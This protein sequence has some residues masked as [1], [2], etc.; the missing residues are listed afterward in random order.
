MARNSNAPVRRLTP[1][2]G[3][4][5]APRGIKPTDQSTKTAAYTPSPSKGRVPD[6]ERTQY[7]I[8]DRVQ[9]RLILWPEVQRKES[10]R[11]WPPAA[12]HV[13][14]KAQPLLARID[15]ARFH[16][17][18]LHLGAPLTSDR[19]T[20]GNILVAVPKAFHQQTVGR[21]KTGPIGPLLGNRKIETWSTQLSS[22]G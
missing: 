21:G 4:R 20:P 19:T 1:A 13:R 8:P 11:V 15:G 14:E 7:L 6:L 9:P 22:G 10:A 2:V 18:Q 3:Q 17:G 16:P 5:P 12:R